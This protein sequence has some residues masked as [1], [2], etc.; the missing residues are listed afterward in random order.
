MTLDDFRKIA[1]AATPGP[2]EWER[3]SED[4]FPQHDQ[5]LVTTWKEEDGEPATVLH[6][7]GYDASGTEAEPQDRLFI[8]T[9]NPKRVLE[10]LA[11]IERLEGVIREQARVLDGRYA[12]LAAVEE[13]HRKVF[14]ICHEC[15]TNWPCETIKAVRGE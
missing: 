12:R 6:G 1:E 3:P 11:Q 8:A 10:L 9:F 13:L 2:W 7:W 15:G 5:S 4:D 14:H